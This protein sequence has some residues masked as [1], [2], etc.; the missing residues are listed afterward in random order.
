MPV[1]PIISRPYIMTQNLTCDDDLTIQYLEIIKANNHLAN[2]D[3]SETKRQ[4]YTHTLIFRIKCLFDNSQDK[5]KHTN[6]RPMKGIKKR[7]CGKEGQIRNNLMGKR[8]DKSARTVI[9]PGP[10]LELNVIEIPKKFAKIISY[11]VQVTKFNIKLLT[12][13]VNNNKANYIIQNNGTRINLN[14]ALYNKK[15]LLE[16]DQIYRGK[17][18]I[19]VTQNNYPKLFSSDKIKRNGKWILNNYINRKYVIEEGEIVERHLQDGDIVLLNRQPTLHKGSM[20]AQKIKIGNTKTIR[21]NLAITKPYNADF[22][23]DE[24]NI[25]VPCTIEGETE[26]RLISDTQHNLISAQA[27]KPNIAIVQDSLLGAYLMTL[28]KKPMPKD[29]FFQIIMKINY[30]FNINNKIK[31]IK[32]ILK[33]KSPYTGSG[34]ISLLLP[35]NL[36]YEK[37]NNA[38]KSEPIFKIYRGVIIK[39]VITKSI[40]GSSHNSLIQI[41]YKEYNTKIAL[42]FINNIQFITNEWLLYNGFSIGIK[43]CIVTKESQI[44]KVVSRCFLE[45]KAV[46]KTSRN[47][48]IREIKITASLSK[49]RDHGMKIAKDAFNH[50]NNF[51]ST[52]TSG[53]KGDYF[54]IAQITGLLGQQ[55][56]TGARIPPVLNDNTRT[57]PH[58]DYNIKV[59]NIDASFESKGFIKHSFSHGLNPREF[60]F[61]AVTGREGITDTAMKTATSGYIQRRMVKASEDVQIKY[62][63]TVRNS[64]NRIIQFIYGDNNL[65]CTQAVLVNGK[66][67]PFNIARL[68]DKINLQYEIS[69]KK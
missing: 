54:N 25:H 36:I 43:D 29:V 8:V 26:L 24:M 28:S 17:D 7:L 22:D 44:R 20:M 4:K 27:S 50:D 2:P 60:W 5:A 39:G 15:Y 53:S 1:L 6:G 9:G 55:N 62:D 11:P 31:Y 14:Y 48:K 33:N 42:Q 45:A 12:D 35:T 67:Q 63:G 64:N 51:I 40:I 16:G 46:E 68:V 52:I 3:I 32:K 49:A 23:G 13:L 38:C 59:E 18:I 21:M 69:K 47:K 37:K 41:L 61:H 66:P 56:L 57:I 58:Y 30:H 19:T 65:D 10:H 34:L